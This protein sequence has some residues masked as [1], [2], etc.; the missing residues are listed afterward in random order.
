VHQLK[1]LSTQSQIPAKCLEYG[2]NKEL[3]PVL[4]NSLAIGHPTKH[5]SRPLK[6]DRNVLQLISSS[7]QVAK[8]L[9]HAAEMKCLDRLY[10]ST[11]ETIQ[12]RTKGEP[13]QSHYGESSLPSTSIES[14]QWKAPINQP[15]HNH[16]PHQSSLTGGWPQQVSRN[17]ANESSLWST[18]TE[19]D[20]WKA[21]IN[22]PQRNYHLHQSSL[23]DGR[24]QQVSHNATTANL[25]YRPHYRLLQKGVHCKK[26]CSHGHSSAPGFSQIYNFQY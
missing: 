5:Q 9:Q 22:Q 1:Q 14:D 17:A 7:L 4:Q 11:E 15:Q 8:I 6:D 16:H 25:V 13:Q 21:A 23:T 18:S 10:S 3:I 19:P 24:P 20:P 12:R 2:R 26:V